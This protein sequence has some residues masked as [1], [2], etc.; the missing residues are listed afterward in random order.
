LIS[1]ATGTTECLRDTANGLV[2]QSEDAADLARKMIWILQNRP[3][4]P[5]MGEQARQTF[6]RSLTHEQY[7]KRVL[8]IFGTEETFIKTDEFISEDHIC[9][10]QRLASVYLR[11]EGIEIGALHK[12]LPVD[13]RKATVRYV[14]YKS[15]EENMIR[16]P[17]LVASGEVIVPTDIVDDGFL[18][19]SLPDGSQD[20]VIANHALEHSP[21]PLGTLGIWL[22]KLRSSGILFVTIPIADRCYDKGRPMTTLEHFREDQELFANVNKQKVLETV[23][24][25]IWEFISISGRN[26]A[27]MNKVTV[28]PAREK[29]LYEQLVKGLSEKVE[30]AH[31]Y[32]ELINAHVTRLNRIYDIHYHTFSPSSYE[33]FL[34]DFCKKKDAVLENVV[35]NGSGECIGIIR[36]K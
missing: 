27:A 16:Y 2:F 25:H 7:Q 17:E 36:K 11:G 15:R 31:T 20:F 18:L 6:D 21:D 19:Q 23:K 8:A 9:S 24:G 12:P 28:S 5:A 34:R 14:D 32:D 22:N 4:L 29:E 35:K 10:R 26:I 1:S 13:Q 33:D 3:L 30:D